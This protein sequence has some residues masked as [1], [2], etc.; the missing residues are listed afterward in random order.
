MNCW[1]SNSIYNVREQVYVQGRKPTWT[2]TYGPFFE[3]LFR[4]DGDEWGA[5]RVCGPHQ[6]WSLNWPLY[7]TSHR[8]WLVRQCCCCCWLLQWCGDRVYLW[9]RVDTTFPAS[10]P[11]GM[12]DRL[13]ALSLSH[14]LFNLHYYYCCYY[15]NVSSGLHHRDAQHTVPMFRQA[16]LCSAVDDDQYV[17]KTRAPA[18]I[19]T[20]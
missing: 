11:C 9:F 10:C 8:F 2:D 12:V 6:I 14:Y 17:S 16:L 5:F 13:A 19:I 18:H 4:S 1:D 20:V 7:G 3:H 15:R